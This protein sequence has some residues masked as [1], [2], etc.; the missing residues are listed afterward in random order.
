MQVGAAVQDI[1]MVRHSTLVDSSG[2]RYVDFRRCLTPRWGIVWTTLLGGHLGLIISAALIVFLGQTIAVGW[3]GAS[4]LAIAGGAELGFFL[5]YLTTYLHEGAHY[6]LAPSR[7]TSDALTNAF[8]GAFIGMNVKAYRKVHFDHHRYLGTT[9]D[10]ERS[11]FNP[12]NLRFLLEGITGVRQVRALKAYHQGLKSNSGAK[13]R[14][15]SLRSEG[16][17]FLPAVAVNGLI[18]IC[19][20][21]LNAVAFAIAWM[22][23]RLVFMPL[24]NTVRQLLEHRS[25]LAD[26][27]TDY[28]RVPH[29]PVNR[30]FGGSLFAALF[31]SAGFNRHLLH[32][33]DPSVSFT[34]LKEVEQFLMKTEIAPILQRRHTTYYRTWQQLGRI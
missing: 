27:E 19:S 25:E 24:F 3:P 21:W 8:I 20:L 2:R 28:S 23:A 9:R 18:I 15:A 5:H 32:H 13:T 30:L 10:P 11:Y 4:V 6:N 22:L 34:R 33:W 14:D 12:L 7:R 17:V 31:G 29:G 16:I 26:D 1:G